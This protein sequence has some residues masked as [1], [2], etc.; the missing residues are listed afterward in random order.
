[1]D[2]SSGVIQ[3]S[4]ILSI[5]MDVSIYLHYHLRD[6][7]ICPLLIYIPVTVFIQ[8]ANH[9]QYPSRSIYV[10]P[11]STQL[12]WESIPSHATE[13]DKLPSLLFFLV[14]SRKHPYPSKISTLYKIISYSSSYLLGVTITR[15]PIPKRSL[16]LASP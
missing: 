4:S 15:V 3:S 12:P 13:S 1:M 16:P 5:H 2:G 9:Q 7:S 11:H 14:T 10:L 8:L 6:L